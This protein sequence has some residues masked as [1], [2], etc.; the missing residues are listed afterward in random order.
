[1]GRDAYRAL[2]ED[3]ERRAEHLAL[4]TTPAEHTTGSAGNTAPPIAQLAALQAS[5]E[6]LKRTFETIAAAPNRRLEAR[7]EEIPLDRM[8]RVDGRAFRRLVRDPACLAAL[9]FAEQPSTG[10]QRRPYVDHPRREQTFDTPPNRHLAY[11]VSRLRRRCQELRAAFERLTAAEDDAVTQARAGSFAEE[12][13]ALE[14]QLRAFERAEFLE[15]VG[16]SVGDAAAMIAVGKDPA[17]S[18]FDREAR[19]VLEPRIALGAGLS[20]RLWLRRTYE[21]YEYWCLFRVADAVSA[22]LGGVRWSGEAVPR[23]GD[24]LADLPNGCR[25][26]SWIGD[27]RLVLTYQHTFRS[28]SPDL[29]EGADP[30]SISGERRPDIVVRMEHQ[31]RHCLIVLDA[32]YR[33]SRK[34]IHEALA[35]MHVYRDSLQ[36]SGRGGKIAAAFIITPAHDPGANVY[37][38]EAYRQRHRIGGFDLAPDG[39][40][41]AARLATSVIQM[42]REMLGAEADIVWP[43]SDGDVVTR[44]GSS[45]R[46]PGAHQ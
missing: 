14:Q 28:Y 32:K 36:M 21:L 17:Y 16:D 26:E 20:E 42:G 27:L 38:T 5:M 40:D 11:L 43:V 45:S 10:P 35:D 46:F 12:A 6:A 1:M 2:V 9:G 15:D 23:V 29:D 44:M 24:L 34:S 19:R 39:Q 4:G 33:C 8:R 3:L 31:G 37:F 30:F 22:A 7:R 18:R 13:G 25:L 41:D